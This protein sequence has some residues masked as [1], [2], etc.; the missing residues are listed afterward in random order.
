[1]RLGATPI[2]ADLFDR[3]SL[4]RAI[5]GH[6]VVIN[7]ATHI[8][9]GWKMIFRRA[10]RENERIRSTGVR[11]LVDAAIACGVERFVQESFAP[12]YPDRGDDWID[13]TMPLDPER[14]NEA[15]LD[16]EGALADFRRRGA[17]VVLRFAAF[18]GPDAD[19]TRGLIAAVR[20]GWSIL[21]GLPQA[22]ISSVSH[23]DA[24]TAVV[25]ALGA[26][27]GIYN[28]GD[29]DPVRR[30]EYLGTLADALGVPPPRQLPA[31]LF[32]SVG[33]AVARSTRISN[34]KL[35]DATGW[36]PR[37]PSVREG[38]TEMLAE[39]AGR[40]P[41]APSPVPPGQVAHP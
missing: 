2:L 22:F 41:H 1:M 10:W 14:Y 3:A 17:G 33:R 27:A 6:D 8:P 4:D 35:R 37:Y 9:A 21:P 7:M 39:L 23:D 30:S 20:H 5:A 28:V 38:W 15:L 26:P 16:A 12:V 32:G 25:A 40:P 34:R 24:A 19:Q 29:D 18:Y 11:N 31:W 36:R 13:E